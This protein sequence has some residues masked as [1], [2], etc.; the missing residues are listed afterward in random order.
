[1][2]KHPKDLA[3]HSADEEYRVASQLD[4]L[5]R[6]ERLW[7]SLKSPLDDPRWR[8]D[9]STRAIQLYELTA[10]VVA[11]HVAD[12]SQ[13]ID[14]AAGLLRDLGDACAMISRRPPIERRM[15]L[16]LPDRAQ[17]EGGVREFGLAEWAARLGITLH[18]KCESDGAQG[19]DRNSGGIDAAQPRNEQ[20][21]DDWTRIMDVYRKLADLRAGQPEL[22]VSGLDLGDA[23]SDF[24]FLARGWMSWAREGSDVG[25]IGVAGAQLLAAQGIFILTH[26]QSMAVEVFPGDDFLRRVLS[27]TGAFDWLKQERV[28]IPG[29]LGVAQS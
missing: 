1:M 21:A 26:R 8:D 19:V 7:Q 27:A 16:S 4:E 11:Q 13:P 17:L 2:T 14:Y 9:M 22:E 3:G 28:E 24:I 23:A 25:T 29:W 20:L 10:P 18:L 15:A 12:A 5:I 6:D